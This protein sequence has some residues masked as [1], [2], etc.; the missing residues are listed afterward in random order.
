MRHWTVDADAPGIV[1][2]VRLHIPYDE[3]PRALGQLAEQWATL[4]PEFGTLDPTLPDVMKLADIGDY[5]QGPDKLFGATMHGDCEDI[6]L[7]AM[8]VLAARDELHVPRRGPV[9]TPWG[10]VVTIPG[11]EEDHIRFEDY[12]ISNDRPEADPAAMGGIWDVLK[13]SVRS[14]APK[15]AKYAL[16]QYVP[17]FGPAL[18]IYSAARKAIRGKPKRSPIRRRTPPPRVARPRPQPQRWQPRQPKLYRRPRVLARRAARRR[19]DPW[20]QFRM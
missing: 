12:D 10:E 7:G 17:G 2:P 5:L 9:M 8:T 15:L 3:I 19:A 1:E 20:G 4:Y 11:E 14:Y 6:V 16:K 18:D 13:R